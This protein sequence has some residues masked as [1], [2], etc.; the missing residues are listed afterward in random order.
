MR[1]CVCRFGSLAILLFVATFLGL[2]LSDSEWLSVSISYDLNL[3]VLRRVAL[4]S[5]HRGLRHLDGDVL[6]HFKEL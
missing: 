2:F 4:V 6:G 5:S 3:G 1:R